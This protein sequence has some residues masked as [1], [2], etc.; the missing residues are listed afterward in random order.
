MREERQ[1]LIYGGRKEERRKRQK[2]KN[3]RT[4]KIILCDVGQLIRSFR[5]QGR[6]WL[7]GSRSTGYDSFKCITFAFQETYC[8]K[9]YLA[10]LSLHASPRIKLLFNFIYT[11]PHKYFI[12]VLYNICEYRTQIK[13]IKYAQ[14]A[15]TKNNE[16]YRL[17]KMLL[18]S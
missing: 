1:R 6:V 10:P 16:C 18:L 8:S 3:E 7:Y 9:C 11:G 14:K 12:H 2:R 5:A 15:L 4:K 17:W 13:G